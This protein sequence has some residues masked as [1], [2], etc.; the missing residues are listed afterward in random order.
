MIVSY[1]MFNETLDV[2]MFMYRNWAIVRMG[3]MNKGFINSQFL[4]FKSEKS[5]ALSKW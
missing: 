3:L 2:L 5:V 1:L 4:L